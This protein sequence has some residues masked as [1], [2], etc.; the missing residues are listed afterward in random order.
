M[1]RRRGR[2]KQEAVQALVAED[3]HV[4]PEQA[5]EGVADARLAM[6]D[7]FR[8]EILPP[9]VSAPEEVRLGDHVDAWII[10]APGVGNMQL[11]TTVTEHEARLRC[12]RVPEL[13]MGEK[14]YAHRRDQMP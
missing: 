10:D 11:R 13:V 14:A 7:G 8:P 3:R 6:V 9:P 4:G 2:K 1:R 12:P 5:P